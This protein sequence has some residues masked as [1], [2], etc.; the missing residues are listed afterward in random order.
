MTGRAKHVLVRAWGVAVALSL[1]ACAGVR[2]P[3]RSRESGNWGP[4]TAVHEVDV[5]GDARSYH[6]HVPPRQPRSRFGGTRALPLVVLLHGSSGSAYDM[7]EASRMDSIA[8][9]RGF[10]VAYPSGSKGR[11]G[12]FR[13]D[14]NAGTCCG[15]AARDQVDDVEFVR[16]LIAELQ[17]RLSVDKRRIYVGGFS[18]GGRMTYRIA[19]ELAPM[20][21]AIAVV[22]GSL[23]LPNCA[24]A[25]P[26]PAIA[27]HGTADPEVP[28]ADSA[29]T[30]PAASVGAWAAALPPVTQFWA[31]QNGCRGATT[32]TVSAHVNAAIFSGCSADLALYTI[33]GGVHGWPGEPTGGA[34]AAPPMSEISASDLMVRF[35][36]RHALP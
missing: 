11:L 7:Q 32:Q 13:S 26:V 12:L 8:D 2:V 19:C 29:L 1:V 31:V 22:S 18:D 15:A 34:G 20:V 27:F 33:D 28:Y 10:L 5:R 36:L 6:L 25:R 24:P 16:R 21:A 35:F 23:A 9:A 30:R 17:Q 4:G 14:W 3:G